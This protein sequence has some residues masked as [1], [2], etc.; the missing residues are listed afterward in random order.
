MLTDVQQRINPDHP[1]AVASLKQ[2]AATPI[3]CDFT[4]ACL[5]IMTR[6]K[7]L[8]L[9]PSTTQVVFAVIFDISQ[10]SRV[11]CRFWVGHTRIIH[12]TLLLL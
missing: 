11:H 6:Q 5:N 10:V 2:S 9:Q 8:Y 12:S 3:S 7:A 4:A 1:V